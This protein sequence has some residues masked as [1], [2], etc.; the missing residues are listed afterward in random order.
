M[1]L[2]D[3]DFTNLVT[4]IYEPDIIKQHYGIIGIRKLLSRAQNPPIQIVI[5]AGLVPKLIKYVQQT[6]YPQLQL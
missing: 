2:T 3:N 6:E 4:A 1:N 5:D